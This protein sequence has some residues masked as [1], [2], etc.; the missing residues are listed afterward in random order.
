MKSIE[1]MVTCRRLLCAAAILVVIIGFGEVFFATAALAG[2]VN[3]ESFIDGDF[4]EAALKHFER[5]FFKKIDATSD[6]QEQLSAIFLKQMQ[7]TR[8]QREEIRHKLLEVTNLMADD[9]ASEEQIREKVSQVKAMREKLNDSRLDTVMKARKVLTP[10]QRK[11]IADR[12]DGLL[13]G[14]SL[15]KNRLGIGNQ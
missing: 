15:L 8:P 11:I 12:I 4:E 14:N 3:S 6:Q 10:E 13:S 1:Q 7:T 5:R 2:R 9:S